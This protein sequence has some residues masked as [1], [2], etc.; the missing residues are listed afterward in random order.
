MKSIR[1]PK[2]P[3]YL[4]DTSVLIAL[5]NSNHTHYGLVL[6]WLTGNVQFATCP[7][8]QGAVIRAYFRESQAPLMEDAH[9]LLKS[10]TGDPSHHFIPDDIDYLTVDGKGLR[11][12]KQVTDA[13]LAQLARHHNLKLATFDSAQAA[14]YPDVAEQLTGA[15]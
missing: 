7:I 8:T 2:S 15:L 5:S 1:K 6:R 3:I 4:L 9:R 14:L 11:G 10:I 13:Y 12:H